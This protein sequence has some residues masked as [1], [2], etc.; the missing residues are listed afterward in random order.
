MT[1]FEAVL[2]FAAVAGLLTLVPG[3][4]T[5]LVLR[6][7]LTHSRRYAWATA[8]GIASGAMA[9]GVAA[10]IGVSALLTASEL[11]YRLLTTIGAAYMCYLGVSMI[12]RSARGSTKRPPAEAAAEVPDASPWRGWMIGAATN[13]LNP[14][15]GIFYIAT[16]PQ[17]LP[18]GTSANR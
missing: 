13:L 9:W 16:I 12:W 1:A 2:A 14:K 5:A 8:V 3:L 7:S 17:F 10:A 11:A 15:V 18:P 6:S 4:D